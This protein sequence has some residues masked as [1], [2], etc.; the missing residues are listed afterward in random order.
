[1]LGRVLT[2]DSLPVAGASVTFTTPGRAPQTTTTAEDGAFGFTGPATGPADI[3]ARRIGFAAESL[4]ITLPRA[5]SAPLAV[6]L[7]PLAQTLAPVV[8][9]GTRDTRSG[10]I[11]GFYARA[12]RGNG[13][14]I[15]RAQIEQ[16]NPLRTTDM[17]R[18]VP[19][20]NVYT[21]LGPSQVRYRGANCPPEVFLDGMPLGPAPFDLDAFP[22]NSIE[23][24]EIYST[25]TAPVE[26]RRAFGR[27]G[28]GTVIV[29]SRQGEPGP[30]RRRGKPVTSEDLAKLVASLQLFTAQQVDTAAR[31]PDD[32][33]ERVGVSDS[34]RAATRTPVVVIAEFV[35]DTT[36]RVEP[37]TIN[38]VVSPGTA[39]S[40]AVRRALPGAEFT[41]A[42][43]GGRTVRQLVQ[44]TVRFDP[45]PAARR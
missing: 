10:P 26:F 4:R 31:A 34:V 5:E 17:L 14:F 22:P 18:L 29:W 19:G 15:T 11:A 45:P 36:G 7:T 8:V 25:S 32:F 9:R 16:R 40:D 35:V 33:G 23:G 41:P 3:Q 2:T 39:Y 30:P 42:V 43:R 38:L 37:A 44:L 12:S 1:V 24:I 6:L 20:V 21:G 27:V 13:R 28:C